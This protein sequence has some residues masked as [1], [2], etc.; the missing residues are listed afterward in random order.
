[1]F[2]F[3]RSKRKQQ[4]MHGTAAAAMGLRIGVGRLPTD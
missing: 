3:Y 1:M 2:E 4:P